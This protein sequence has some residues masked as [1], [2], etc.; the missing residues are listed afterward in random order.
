LWTQF[1]VARQAPF[2]AISARQA[3]IAALVQDD[4]AIAKVSNGRAP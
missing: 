2:N 3:A 4:P 1:D